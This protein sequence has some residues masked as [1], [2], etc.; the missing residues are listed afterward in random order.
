MAADSVLP[1]PPGGLPELLDSVY[2]LLL[3]AY[4]PQGWW[5]ADS[6]FEMIAG[7]ILTQSTNWG[8]VEKA[9]DNLRADG[10]WSF[11]AVDALPE[12]RLAELIRP[13]G[14]FNAKARKLKAFAAHLRR[15]HG[16]SLDR[17]LAQE[18]AALRAELLGIY[19]IGEETADDIIV[20][21]AGLPSFVIDVYTRRIIDRMG[22]RPGDG[23]RYRDYQALFHANLPA[24]APLFNEYHA[25]LDHHAK[26]VCRKTAPRC[27]GCCLADLCA[28]GQAAVAGNPPDEA[29]AG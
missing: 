23:V 11:A 7:A 17:L 22:W 3:D 10:C 16:G 29:A 19:G 27:A 13:S 6:P 21:A 8:N 1:L 14:Y 20:Y 24:E 18:T 2:R 4:G 9:L 28:T 26:L 12:A 25:L 15:R 5:P